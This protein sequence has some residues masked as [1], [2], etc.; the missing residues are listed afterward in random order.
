MAPKELLHTMK[1]LLKPT[2]MALLLIEIFTANAA[3]TSIEFQH[4]LNCQVSDPADPAYGAI[5]DVWGEPTWVVPGEMAVAALVL[6]A[7]GYLTQAKA[8]ADYLVKV[9]NTDGSWCNQ[10]DHLTAVDK[11]KFTRHTAQVMM[12]LGT[13]GGYSTAL[14][15][16]NTWLASMQDPKV[17][18]GVDD[19][20]VCGGKSSTGG[21]YTDRWVSDNSFA[22]RAF[23]I[24][25]NSVAANKVVN[26]IN[27]YLVNGDHWYQRIT[28]QGRKSDGDFGWINWAPAFMNLAG[29][30]VTYPPGL[31]DG[32]R[33]RLQVA[34]GTHKGAVYENA[35][36]TKLMPGI[37]FQASIAWN[38]LGKSA[39]SAEHTA[40]A[41]NVSGLWVTTVDANGDIGGW[42]DWRTTSG[43]KAEWWQR[44]IDTSAY[45]IMTV[46][47]W[48]F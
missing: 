34:T 10:Y 41:E 27:T 12:L 16:A 13:I 38:A 37:G 42:I 47:G 45:Y 46:N 32:I 1:H 14:S 29:D 4:I 33:S 23:K 31:A 28:S 19:G 17:K 48:Q 24:A 20:L 18:T 35:K 11:N 9:Q 3:N 25:G 40:W 15:K 8:A 22:V 30:G 43:Q 39:Y 36:S 5:N 7:G 6:K 21:T 44:F 2:I 26:G